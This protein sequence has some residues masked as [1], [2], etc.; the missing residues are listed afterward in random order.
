MQV[1]KAALPNVRYIAFDFHHE[2]KG[3]KYE[4]LSKLLNQMSDEFP[5]MG[6]F[7]AEY[8]PL[9]DDNKNSS[10]P[11]YQVTVIRQQQVFLR[12]TSFLLF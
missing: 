1:E 6:Y 7:H 5:A 9:D 3:M 10:V 8:T 12:L 2:C 4:N 11:T